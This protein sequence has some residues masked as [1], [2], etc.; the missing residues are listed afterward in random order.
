MGYCRYLVTGD[1]LDS[2]DKAVDTI[3]KGIEEGVFPGEA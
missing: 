3:V 2:F 1:V